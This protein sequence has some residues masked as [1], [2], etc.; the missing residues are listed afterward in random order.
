LLRD[1]PDKCPVHVQNRWLGKD[2]IVV[3]LDDHFTSLPTEVFYSILFYSILFYSILFYS[4]LFYS[5][6]FHSIPFH[7]ILFNSIIF[8]SIAPDFSRLQ[9]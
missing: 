8:Y 9:V 4:I 3:E 2:N 7:S 5:I 1:F 6:P